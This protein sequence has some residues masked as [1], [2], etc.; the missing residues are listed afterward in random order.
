MPV[1]GITTDEAETLLGYLGEILATDPNP[2]LQSVY[3]QL[4]DDLEGRR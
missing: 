3:D 1:L 2:D 4:A